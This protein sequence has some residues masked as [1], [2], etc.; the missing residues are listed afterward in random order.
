MQSPSDGKESRSSEGTMRKR[1]FTYGSGE[2]E[3]GMNRH[4]RREHHTQKNRALSSLLNEARV[5]MDFGCST[6]SGRT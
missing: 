3:N 4:A 5:M 1:K 6:S 2:P